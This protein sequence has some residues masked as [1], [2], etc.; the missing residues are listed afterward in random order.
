MLHVSHFFFFLF[1]FYYFILTCS[2]IFVLYVRL[3]HFKIKITYTVCVCVCVLLEF[4]IRPVFT[5]QVFSPSSDVSVTRAL[6]PFK[7]NRF[8]WVNETQALTLASSQPWLP[9]LRP[10][11]PIGWRLRLLREI[12]ASTCVSCGFHLRNASDC[13]CTETGLE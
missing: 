12:N 2:L 13:V 8:R 10:S 6:F 1:F 7:R 11:I 3:S 5:G 9:L 4:W